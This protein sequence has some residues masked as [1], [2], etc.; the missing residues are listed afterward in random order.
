MCQNTKFQVK[1]TKKKKKK[2]KTFRSKMPDLEKF[3]SVFEKPIFIFEISTLEFVKMQSF[4]LKNEKLNL[5]PKLSYLGIFGLDFEK[6]VVLFKI[7]IFQFVKTQSFVL[8]KKN[9]FGTKISLFRYF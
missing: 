1:A 7:I 2:K 4:L 8:K 9:Q 5:G 6:T 3:K